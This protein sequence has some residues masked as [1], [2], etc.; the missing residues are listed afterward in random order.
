M[1]DLEHPTKAGLSLPS[2]PTPVYTCLRRVS[3]PPTPKET[4]FPA[5]QQT[6]EPHIRRSSL[7]HSHGHGAADEDT[8]A[9]T[10]RHGY[11]LR[12][13]ASPSL[14]RKIAKDKGEVPSEIPQTSLAAKGAW[15]MLTHYTRDVSLIKMRTANAQWLT[16]VDANMIAAA[17]VRERAECEVLERERKDRGRNRSESI[18]SKGQSSESKKESEGE[19]VSDSST[20]R[21]SGLVADRV[22]E[23]EVRKSLDA[24]S[25]NVPHSKVNGFEAS[26]TVGTSTGDVLRESMYD[27]LSTSPPLSSSTAQQ[28]FLKTAEKFSEQRK[29]TSIDERRLIH[30]AAWC[31]IES[32]LDHYAKVFRNNMENP[33]ASKTIMWEQLVELRKRKDELEE[34]RKV[35]KLFRKEKGA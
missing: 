18:F 17:I 20:N 5:Y 35:N 28:M 32:H 34:E 19:E 29:K 3:H 24:D 11:S 13:S 6:L 23:F 31:W 30:E 22:R 15:R 14:A 2:H 27:E 9:C 16:S 26:S 21:K 10:H 12:T 1:A 33:R 4:Q 7:A 8:R 25:E